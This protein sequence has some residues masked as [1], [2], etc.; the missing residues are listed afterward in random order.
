MSVYVCSCDLA[1]LDRE[2]DI[3]CYLVS[4][5]CC[6][7]VEYVCTVCQILYE[8]GLASAYPYQFLAVLTCYKLCS[9]AKLNLAYVE[10]YVLSSEVLACECESCSADL[11]AEYV[12]LADLNVCYC[13]IVDHCYSASVAYCV[14]SCYLTVLDRE[15]DICCYFIAAWCCYFVQ[16]VCSVCQTLD[17]CGLASAY[18]Y[19]LISVLLG[20]E[21]CVLAKYHVINVEL[22]LSSCHVCSCQCQSCSLDLFAEYVLLAYC[23]VLLCHVVCESYCIS[24]NSCIAGNHTVLDCECD[25][26]CYFVSAW[27]CYFVK[28]VCTVC[29]SLY[30][31]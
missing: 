18:P 20:N 22:D 19:Q 17:L 24:C 31:C 7:L 9:F 10:G 5:W 14:A 21:L 25:V 16:C 4:A 23:Y 15:C 2:C 29:Q 12:C 3:C 6:H 1:I 30:E 13:H 26:C 11:I 8:C 28:C 27:C